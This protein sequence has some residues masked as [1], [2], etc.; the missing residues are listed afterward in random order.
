MYVKQAH[1]TGIKIF[2]CYCLMT[3]DVG[4]FLGTLYGVVQNV[5]CCKCSCQGG[6]DINM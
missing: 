6:I 4:A 2:V 3:L 1:K 5:L